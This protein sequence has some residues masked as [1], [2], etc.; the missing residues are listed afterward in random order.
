L[1]ADER[2]VAAELEKESLKLCDEGSLEIGLAVL[3]F[4]VQELEDI[5]LLDF[6][7]WRDDIVRRRHLPLA[8][9]RR[10]VPRQSRALKELGSNL[11]V[12]LAHSPATA[13]GF[14]LVEVAGL[15]ASYREQPYIVRPGQ[16]E[17]CSNGTEVDGRTR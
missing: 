7:L 4:Q 3:V 14:G 8:E 17:L 15:G 2:E 1:P 10:L 13:K 12:E 9:H 16:L 6:L 5:G 11:A